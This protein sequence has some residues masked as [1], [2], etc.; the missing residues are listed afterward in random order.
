MRQIFKIFFQ[1]EEQPGPG[2]CL[3]CLLLGGLAE[4][5]GIGTL[6]PVVSFSL[7]HGIRANFTI[8]TATSA[9]GFASIGMC[10]KF[11]QHD[12]AG[13][14]HHDLPV[15]PAVCGHE[16]CRHY[17]APRANR[18]C[19]AI[20]PRRA[21]GALELS[22]PTRAAGSSQQHL[23]MMRA[24]PAKP[25]SVCN[26]HCLQRANLRLCGCCLADQLA[27]GARWHC[28]VACWS[29]LRRRDLSTFPV[30]AGF[31]QSDR[32]GADDI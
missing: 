21:G 17:S 10:T 8:R 28:Q 22:T 29:P 14:C 30:C 32:I 9:I 7:E 2:W 31:K 5:I 4:A 1:A 16:L 18:V 27:R 12:H 13:C 25:I 15:G 20:H 24:A 11:R 23:A 19:A 3:M 6:L 26:G